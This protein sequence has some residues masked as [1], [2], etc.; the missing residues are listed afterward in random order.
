MSR[1]HGAQPMLL[2]QTA[3]YALRAMAVLA[4]RWSTERVT[5]SQLA[6][7]ANIPSHYVSKVMRRLVV[8]GLVDARRGHHGGFR[9]ARAPEEITFMQV[10]DAVDFQSHEKHCAFGLGACDP[11]NPCILHP[12]YSA[13][14]DCFLAWA[15]STTL[16]SARE[17]GVDVLPAR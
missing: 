10:L 8:A 15:E 1:P 5:S 13:L 16:V 11:D 6:R 7:D 3:E 9:L 14:Q 12:A 2:T 17:Q 4:A